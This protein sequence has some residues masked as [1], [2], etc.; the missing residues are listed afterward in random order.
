MQISI[1]NLSLFLGACAPSFRARHVPA[2]RASRRI[3]GGIS[4]WSIFAAFLVV[5]GLAS[6]KAA[7][8]TAHLSAYLTPVGPGNGTGVYFWASGVA[9]DGQGNVYITDD[10]L[11]Q[12]VMDTP[13]GNGYAQTVLPFTGLNQPAG[14]AVDLNGDVFVADTGNNRVV[15]LTLAAG[16]YTQSTLAQ[17]PSSGAPAGVAVDRLGNVYFTDT[18]TG[19]VTMETLSGGVYTPSVI[20]GGEPE[21]P[22]AVDSAGNVYVSGYLG[23]YGE[24]GVFMLTP[25]PSGYTLSPFYLD[26]HAQAFAGL[27]VDSSNNVYF[28]YYQCCEKYPQVIEVSGGVATDAAYTGVYGPAGIAVDASGNLYIVDVGAKIGN[29]VQPVVKQSPVG[30]VFQA[31]DTSGFPQFI[32]GAIFTFDTG[33]TLASTVVLTQ[34][35]TE[36][37]VQG[38]LYPEITAYSGGGAGPI[39]TAGTAYNAG[40]TCVVWAT[41]DARTPGTHYGAIELHDASGHELATAFIE[42]TN[43]VGSQVNFYPGT[44]SSIGSGFSYPAGV[45][46]DASGNVYVADAGLGQVL[47][48]TP[49]GGSYS[50]SVVPFGGFSSPVSVAIDGA[51]N[52]YV[53]DSVN[54]AL[55]KEFLGAGIGTI[56]SGLNLP[57]GVAVDGQG[58]VFVADTYNHQ[59]LRFAPVQGGYSASTVVGSGMAHPAGVAVDGSGNVYIA[60][61]VNNAVYLETLTASGYQQSTIGSNLT[62]PYG[63]AVDGVGNVFITELGIPGAVLK[64]TL[65]AGGYVQGPGAVTSESTHLVDP[66]GIAVDGNGNLYIAS[67]DAPWVMKEDYADAPSLSFAG[68]AV[69]STSSPATQT[70]ENVGNYQLVFGNY[71]LSST[72][73]ALDSSGA[74]ACPITTYGATLAPAASCEIQIS[75]TPTQSGAFTGS[76]GIY[77]SNL[78][79]KPSGYAL[80]TINLSG[81]GEVPA[82][83]PTFGLAAGTY[84]G[85]QSV[86]ISDTT[87]GATIYY[88]TNGGTPNTGSAVYGGPLTVSYPENISAIAVAPGYTESAVAN[89]IYNVTLPTTTTIMSNDNPSPVGQSVTFTANI[90]S[91]APLPEED[92]VVFSVD[93]ITVATVGYEGM[94][95][96]QTSTLSAGVHTVTVTFP[97]DFDNAPSSASIQQTVGEIAPPFGH[98]DTAVDSVT[99]NSPI[100]Q[101]DSVVL[102][103]WAADLIDGAPLSNVKVYI[104]GNLIGTPTLGIARPDVAAAK[105]AAYL[106]SGYTLTYSA[107]ALSLGSHAATVIAIDSGGRSTTFGPLTFTVAAVAGG[108]LPVGHIDSA[109]DSVTASS[110]VG[111]ADSVVISGWAADL[112]DHAPLSNVTVYIDGNSV[113]TPTLGIARP[114]VAAAKGAVYLDSGFQLSYSAAALSLGAHAVTV[115]AIDSGGRSTTFGPLAFTV[116]TDA[117]AAPPTPPFGNLDSA[118]DSVT[119]SSTVAQSDSVV[120][121]GWAADVVDGAPL[122]NVTVYIDGNTVGTPTLGI[123][124]KDVAAVEGAAYLDSGYELSYS[125]AALDAGSHSVTVTAI[126]SGGRSRTFGPL[127][128]TVP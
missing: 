47:L 60:D 74:S 22:I 100:G 13:V 86:S 73:L 11:N 77:D 72:Q 62:S 57:T 92:N 105:G 97:G 123:A 50:Q 93:G 43:S 116:A 87:P 79:A 98:L 37:P 38:A 36:V 6:G 59:V 55:Y 42:G 71:G 95:I 4:R 113:G 29:Y 115:I 54:G 67:G 7:A 118:L 25:G 19:Y 34:G 111:Q 69:G 8:Q 44:Q 52:L 121:K 117:G 76:L 14:V 81:T 128:F 107:A 12:V 56:A 94:A 35:A 48:E 9:V 32:T 82:A 122:S 58:N 31:S 96:Y 10:Y 45:A 120:V 39:C 70:V 65:T 106:D 109:V 23:G 28:S 88:T 102:R 33:G 63:V 61:E 5:I 114:D 75:F 66:T 124:R 51:G 40:D 112:V 64:E 17:L 125:A 1:R 85:A 119:K 101:A 15:M 49:S 80:Q 41:D 27:A 90:G 53:V 103:G 30:G 84:V 126:D 91:A 108:A 26:S 21:G 89:A 68:T 24:M 18:A 78:N 99:G 2:A 3:P 104:D 110:T 46:V 16:V 20:T 127:A 83:T